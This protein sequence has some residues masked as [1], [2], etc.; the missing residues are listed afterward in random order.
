MDVDWG[1]KTVNVDKADMLLIQSTP[2]EVRQLNLDDFRLDLADIQDDEEGMP[3]LDIFRHNPPV[4]IAGVTLSR[5]VEIIN[6]YTLTFEDGLYNVNITGGNSNVAD[7]VNKNQVGVN[8]AN[9]AGLQDLNTILVASY[10]SRVVID[11]IN[12]QAGTA[13]PL[14]TL[15][16]P[17]DNVADAVTIANTNGIS[18][19]FII[20]DLTLTTGDDVSSLTIRG[21]N[22]TL[23]T[24]TIESAANVADC[25]IV[26]VTLEG[27]LDGGTTIHDAVL[28]TVDYIQGMVV[29]CG[30]NEGTITLGGMMEALFINCYSMV[31]GSATPTI[32]LNGNGHS[33]GMRGYS[34]GIELLNK[35]DTSPVS[36]D[37]SS[38]HLK[39]AASCDAGDITARG[40]YKLTD[41]STGTCEVLTDG[42][43]IDAPA[44]KAIIESALYGKLEI[45]AI[46]NTLTIYDRDTGGV[47]QVFDLFDENG[48]SS[49]AKVFKRE[50]Q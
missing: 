40:I 29:N 36:L 42:R 14:G 44:A 45:D 47:I 49:S 6:G 4:T 12:G 26:G 8:T 2:V 18:E 32:D 37:F 19:L 16:T 28:G 3:F 17:V 30:L 46:A 9:S 24:L 25:E 39:V 41:N 48:T 23:T 13:V 33:L 34:G 1:T 27:T 43:A 20:G 21:Q 50:L 31:S 10:D 7:V 5:V 11:V 15:S 38:G 22:S 35:T